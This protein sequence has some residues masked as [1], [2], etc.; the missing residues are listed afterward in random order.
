MNDDLEKYGLPS[1]FWKII[2]EARSPHLWKKKE[3][4]W[5]LKYSL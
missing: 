3:N 4:Q 2:D 5:K 1:E